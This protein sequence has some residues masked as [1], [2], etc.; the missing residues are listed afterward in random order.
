[1]CV[2][3]NVYPLKKGYQTDNDD[4]ND[5]NDDVDDDDDDDGVYVNI[6]MCLPTFGH[7]YFPCTHSTIRS[8]MFMLCQKNPCTQLDQIHISPTH[9]HI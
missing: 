3:F 6:S 2:H 8:Y 5:D 7:N 4:D 1:V 9:T